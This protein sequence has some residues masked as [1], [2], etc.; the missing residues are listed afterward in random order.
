MGV[1]HNCEIMGGDK[2]QEAKRLV[3]PIIE[4]LIWS[5]VKGR[6]GDKS[7][8]ETDTTVVT[9]PSQKLKSRQK[10]QLEGTIGKCTEAQMVAAPHIN[11]GSAVAEAAPLSVSYTEGFFV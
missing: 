3:L 6:N 8:T 9:L 4:S 2:G 11:I 1:A 10:L 5:C 7:A